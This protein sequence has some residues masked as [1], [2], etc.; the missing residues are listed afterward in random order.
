MYRCLGMLRM[1]CMLHDRGAAAEPQL[2][3]CLDYA[4]LH[5]TSRL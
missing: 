5:A 1:R 4:I 2:A 3:V